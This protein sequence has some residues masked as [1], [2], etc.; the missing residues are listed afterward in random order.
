MVEATDEKAR[1]P[2][3]K[4]VTESSLDERGSLL[5]EIEREMWVS[6]SS[7]VRI[8]QLG[9]LNERYHQLLDE[10]YNSAN[11][12]VDRYQSLSRLHWHWR[13]AV[14]IGTGIVALA[15]LF[16]AHKAGDPKNLSTNPALIAAVLAVVLTIIVNLESFVNAL[17]R[18][19]SYR[20]SRELFLDV[21]REFD[22]RWDIYVRPLGDNPEACLNASELYRQLVAKDRELRT[23]FKE[24][25]KTDSK[26][27]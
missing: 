26:K 19:Q 17:D 11:V 3:Q 1:P 25:T 14:I 5:I 9:L 23:K 13:R 20:E 8:E 4:R 18:A 7:E 16:T 2:R 21:A 12:C 27:K 6:I 10:I 24:L 15:N 22:R